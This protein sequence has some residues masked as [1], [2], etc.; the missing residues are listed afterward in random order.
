MRFN[1]QFAGCRSLPQKIY[2]ETVADGD[3][4]VHQTI[5][6]MKT[7]VNGPEGVRCPD[8]RQAALEAARGSERGMSEID[9]VFAWIKDNIEFRGEWG[10]TL[11]TPKMTLYYRAGDCDDQSVL[12]AA[13]LNSLGYMTR[14][15]TVA[16]QDTAEDLSHV[17]VE[18]L[19]RRT[20]QWVPVDTTVARA[21][22]GWEPEGV[23]R[24]IDYAPTGGNSA[25]VDGLLA[26]GALF[27]F[28]V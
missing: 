19:D 13:I 20:R 12:Q 18:V 23:A 11:Q 10:E 2:S 8:V 15:K 24:A 22:P 21:Y 4:G 5:A 25:A 7:L 26:L 14:F 28:G 6:L 9:A 3:M 16:L 27:L 1:R 17:Y